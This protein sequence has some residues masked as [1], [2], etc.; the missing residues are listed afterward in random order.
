MSEK[1][2]IKVPVASELAAENKKAEY[3]FW[4]GSAGSYDDRAKKITRA[5]VQIL[6]HCKVNYAI[7]GTDESDS[8]DVAKRAGNEFAYQMQ[9]MQNIEVMNSLEVKKIIKGD[10]HDY[11]VIKNEYPELDGNYEVIHHTEFINKLIND[12]TLK[13][14]K[15]YFKDKKVTYHDPCYLGRGNNIYDEP[16]FVLKQISSDFVEMQRNKKRA[17]C[18]GAGGAQMFKE[19]EKGNQEIYELRTED[20]LETKANLIATACPFCMTMMMDGLKMIDKQDEIK[21][22]DIAELI[23]MSKN[24]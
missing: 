20:A 14:D 4:V 9:A 5:F 21:V 8:G 3:I 23:A 1:R 16:R 22:Y 19:A 24:L 17:L 7:L 12:G 13:L 2:K 18:C 15:E 11:N 6:E 10:P